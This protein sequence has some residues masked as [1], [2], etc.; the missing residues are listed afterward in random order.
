MRLNREKG[1]VWNMTYGRT[2]GL[3]N[4]NGYGEGNVVFVTF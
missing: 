4:A 1:D 2:Q 3:L